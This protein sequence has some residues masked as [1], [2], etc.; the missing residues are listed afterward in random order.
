MTDDA[1]LPV[2]AALAASYS[3][4]GMVALRNLLTADDI[5]QLRRECDELRIGVSD[6]ELCEADCVLPLPQLESLPES[7]C[8]R[9]EAHGYAEARGNKQIAH[10]LLRTLSAAAGAALE[11]LPSS[12]PAASALSLIHI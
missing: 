1:D 7:H 12:P 4:R 3:R 5:H 11:P 9:A 10:L 2:Q 8:A 6:E